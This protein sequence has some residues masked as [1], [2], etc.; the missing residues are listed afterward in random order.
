MAMFLLLFIISSTLSVTFVFVFFLF[1]F[2]YAYFFKI[3]SVGDNNSSSKFLP[4]E[5]D[6]LFKLNVGIL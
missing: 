5:L 6:L 2:N 4:F 1:N 3:L